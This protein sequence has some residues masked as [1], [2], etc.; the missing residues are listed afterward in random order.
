VGAF[1][2]A[3]FASQSFYMPTQT[4]VT[5]GTLCAIPPNLV[6]KRNKIAYSQKSGWFMDIYE[7]NGHRL[8]NSD[9]FCGLESVP[10]KS[11]DL[12]FID[13]PYNIG[14][15]FNTMKDK[16]KTDEGYLNWSY[17]WI[18]ICIKKLKSNGSL[19]IMTSTQF[20]PYFDIYIRQKMT[21]L[22]RIVWVL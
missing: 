21:I 9:V 22:S 12:V 6:D 14:K 13:P 8:I 5:A 19:Y 7:Q 20:M 16:W 10:K 2:R 3:V 15:D 1:G 18:D 11:I 17:R 4:L